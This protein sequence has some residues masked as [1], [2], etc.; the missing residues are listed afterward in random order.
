MPQSAQRFL[1]DIV[2]FL[3]FCSV[4]ENYESP[5]QAR[6]ILAV[7]VGLL[8][9]DRNRTVGDT[10]TA[11]SVCNRSPN[12]EEFRRTGNKQTLIVYYSLERLT[13]CRR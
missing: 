11:Q 10:L 3:P 2:L 7:A 5:H 1:K 6:R 12:W 8:Q 9:L 13:P 4:E